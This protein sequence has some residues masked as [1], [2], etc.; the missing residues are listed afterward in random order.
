[1]TFEAAPTLVELTSLVIA[2]ATRLEENNAYLIGANAELSRQLNACFR[3]LDR[4]GLT[5]EATAEMSK[6]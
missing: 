1:M 4:H 2:R 6:P 3:V 5:K